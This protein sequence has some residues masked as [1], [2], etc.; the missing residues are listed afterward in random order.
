[1]T[2]TRRYALSAILD[3]ITEEDTDG[4]SCI[5]ATGDTVSKKEWRMAAGFKWN[6]QRKIWCKYAA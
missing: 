5:V 4:Q 1:M 3:I 6:P 2:Y